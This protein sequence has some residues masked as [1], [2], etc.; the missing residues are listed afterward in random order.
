MREVVLRVPAHALDDVLDRILPLVPDGVRESP[1]PPLQV[2]LRMRGPQLPS[3]ATIASPVR[4]RNLTGWPLDIDRDAG[5]LSGPTISLGDVD[6]YAPGRAD[7]GFRL[8]SG[9]DLLLARIT[10][11]TLRF[12]ER[13]TVRV[14]TQAI[15]RQAGSA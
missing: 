1:A 12:P 9:D 7:L 10:I 3:L 6:V 5:S 2:E 13:G 14:S 8:G 15:V 11:A 4:S